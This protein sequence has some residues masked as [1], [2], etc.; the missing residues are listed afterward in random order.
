MTAARSGDRPYDVVVF[1]ATGFTGGKTAEY[2]ARH[3]PKSLKWAIAGRSA[4]KLAAVKA[5]LSAIEP[6]LDVGVVEASSED[7][8]SLARM[9]SAAR[10]VL[11][12]VGPFIDYGE[13]LVKACIEAGTDYV[14]S[15][16]E[17]FFVDRLLVRYRDAAARAGVR[18]VSSCGFDTIPADLGV[19]FTLKQ[20]PE[21]VPVRV[22]GYMKLDAQFS[23]GT[24]RSAIKSLA[25]PEGAVKP[26]PPQPSNGRRVRL[27]TEK[28]RRRP[29]LAGW[30]APLPTLDGSVVVRSAASIDRYG[31]DFS[32]SHNVIQ[33][34]LLLTLLAGMFFGG[35]AL[36]V[37]VAFIRNLLVGMA[38]K[39]GQGPS[40]ERMAKSWFKLRFVAESDGKKI[41]TEVSGGDP[42][43]GETS[44]MLAESAL[45]L[46]LDRDALPART[47]ILTPAEAMGDV[48]IERLQ[49][50]GLRF[51]VVD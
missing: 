1:G 26:E 44:K 35:L 19:L 47:G 28:V 27:V 17:P 30:S 50:A 8:A 36:V 37:R 3:A 46:A 33:P 29:D 34:S 16:G 21:G 45:C 10:V 4:Q 12:T 15:T 42:G 51:A 20:L 9:A 43:Y 6:A 22:A 13:P 24:E 2:L 39:S 23:G 48:L 11:T 49:R 40:E 31:P 38:K 5:R 7:P 25:P 14:D 41:Q 32:Y 18:I